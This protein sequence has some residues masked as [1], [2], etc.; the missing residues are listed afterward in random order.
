MSSAERHTSP[1][2]QFY[3]KDFLASSAVAEMNLE[4]VGAFVILL[5][6][7]WNEDGLPEDEETLAR[8][9]RLPQKKFTSIWS[10]VRSRFELSN[11]KWRN[12]RL[13]VERA[14]QAINRHKK[15]EAARSRWDKVPEISNAPGLRT[16][17]QPTMQ[18]QCIATATATSDTTPPLTPPDDVVGGNC[19]KRRSS[20]S[21]SRGRA[22]AVFNDL[23]KQRT[24]SQFPNGPLY[25]LPKALLD[26][27]PEKV[28]VAL[29]IAGGPVRVANAE[30]RDL[31][32]VTG[33]FAT[34]LAGQEEES[35]GRSIRQDASHG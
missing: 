26:G 15:Q 31:A 29:T 5:A 34:A 30:D 2:F 32:V 14:K 25:Q 17:C 16:H 23:R 22:M 27:L 19:V 28:R 8:L 6:Y 3:P 4:Q 24:R 35:F 33:Q 20:T 11:G 10:R 7:A 18:E 9:L 21:I 12:A 1:A 13:E